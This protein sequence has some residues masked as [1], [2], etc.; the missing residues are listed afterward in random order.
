MIKAFAQILITSPYFLLGIFVLNSNLLN[1]SLFKI[2]NM[3]TTI[4]SNWQQFTFTNK[5]LLD[6]TFY[7]WNLI[8][9]NPVNK[10]SSS[11]KCAIFSFSAVLILLSYIFF[12]VNEN[13]LWNSNND[14]AVLKS[15]ISQLLMFFRLKAKFSLQWSHQIEFFSIFPFMTWFTTSST[16]FGFD[17]A[18]FPHQYV[19]PFTAGN[20]LSMFVKIE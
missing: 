6:R 3:N 20:N 14:M 16:Y 15:N 4:G 13:E 10:D 8:S 19:S 9:L 11:T 1:A 18:P 12:W 17:Q 2:P 5:Q 7:D